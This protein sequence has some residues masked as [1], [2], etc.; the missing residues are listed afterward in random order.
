MS[1]IFF[2]IISQKWAYNSLLQNIAWKL[3]YPTLS[4]INTAKK[5]ANNKGVNVFVTGYPIFDEI[6]NHNKIRKDP[7]IINDKSVKRIIWAPHHSIESDNSLQLSNFLHN[8][9][10]ILDLAEKYKTK[11]QI[12]FKPHPFLISKLYNHIEWG[13]ERADAYYKKWESK[14]NC[15]LETGEYVDLMITSDAMI[16]DSISFTVEYLYTK[17]P[18]FY[19]SKKNHVNNLCVFGNLAF[20]QH[21]NGF[22]DS[23]IEHFISEIVV[24]DKDPMKLNRSKFFNDF[25]IPPNNQSVANN[26]LSEILIDLESNND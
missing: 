25:L 11:I 1:L 14:S 16:H 21:Y 3:F 23:Q 24:N 17:K 10:L 7:W 26:I 12:A 4:H 8:Y 19:V 2:P 18:V 6:L 9:D 20:D 5:F 22:S 13:K 15:Q